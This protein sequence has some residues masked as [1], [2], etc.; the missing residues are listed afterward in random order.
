MPA[1]G[2]FGRRRIS[3]AGEGSPS[4]S[5][6]SSSRCQ[7]CGEPTARPGLVYCPTCAVQRP[8]ERRLLTALG[9]AATFPPA[10]YLCYHCSA[11]VGPRFVARPD[12]DRTIAV[13]TSCLWRFT[14]AAAHPEWL[15]PMERA[16]LLEA[17]PHL[18]IMPQPDGTE[19]WIDR[20]E[21]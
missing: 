3:Q 11:P 4:P 16:A 7:W 17:F 18:E 12:L 9:R 14:Q 21:E 2:P 10:L 20:G 19:Y 13:C 5:P 8:W 6:A 1:I 15:S